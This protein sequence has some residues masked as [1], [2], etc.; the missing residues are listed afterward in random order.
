[1]DDVGFEF[2]EPGKEPEIYH[3]TTLTGDSD[4]FGT[5]DGRDI[6]EH[7]TMQE[8]LVDRN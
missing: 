8:I 3:K 4:T 5:T 6:C 7:F 1:M 2:V